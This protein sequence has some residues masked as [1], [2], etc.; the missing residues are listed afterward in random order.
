M[1]HRQGG[2]FGP[3]A[4]IGCGIILRNRTAIV[5]RRI[6]VPQRVATE[7]TAINPRRAPL[8]PAALALAACLLAASAK[9]QIRL[10]DFGDP[11]SAV[12]S[13]S[14]ERELGEETAR[15]FDLQ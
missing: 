8:L 13:S 1:N 7:R 12:I 4:D 2:P 11:S 9:A 3:G 14:V 6:H 5:T 10:P 15:A